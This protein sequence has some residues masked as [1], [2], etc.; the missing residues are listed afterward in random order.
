MKVVLIRHT[1][2]DVPQGTCYGQTDVPV[3]STFPEEA[4]LVKSNLEASLPFDKVFCS[5]LTRAVKLATYCG[6]PDAE[7]DDR[8]LEL[9]M[10]D[11]EMQRFEDIHVPYVNEWYNDY[12]H[13]PTPNGESFEM[14]YHRV[15]QFLDELRQQPYENVAIFAHGG[16]LISAQVYAGDVSFD[17]AFSALVPYGGIVQIVLT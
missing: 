15:C 1:S 2:V 9:N 11:W 14:Q 3:K 13:L 17:N 4:A 16:V 6:Y 10:G 12:L 5:P 7:R 8:L